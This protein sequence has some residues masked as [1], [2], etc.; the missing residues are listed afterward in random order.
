MYCGCWG[1]SWTADGV[2]IHKRFRLQD[3][4]N[5]ATPLTDTRYG[6]LVEGTR[7][8]THDGYMGQLLGC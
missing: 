2:G 5:R 8:A 7:L 3:S 6:Q 1:R 4:A